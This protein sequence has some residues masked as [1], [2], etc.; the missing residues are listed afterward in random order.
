MIIGE[1][2]VS[3]SMQGVGGWRA[4]SGSRWEMTLKLGLRRRM[5]VERMGLNDLNR[6]LGAYCP[7]VT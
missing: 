7:I 5:G 6:V 1:H 2:L 4:Q 3:L